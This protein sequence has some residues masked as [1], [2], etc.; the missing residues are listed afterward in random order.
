M[1]LGS[2]VST[3]DL[4]STVFDNPSHEIRTDSDGQAA[5]N[6]L[7]R[8]TGTITLPD[9]FA[10]RAWSIC[11]GL[12]RRPDCGDRRI[13]NAGNTSSTVADQKI[14]STSKY[15]SW[16]SW[17]VISK[18]GDYQAG[19]ASGAINSYVKCLQIGKRHRFKFRVHDVRVERKINN[20][21]PMFSVTVWGYKSGYLSGGR[22]QYCRYQASAGGGTGVINQQDVDKYFTPNATYPY[23]VINVE[24]L[25]TGGGEGYSGQ[26]YGSMSMAEMTVE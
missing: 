4:A 18:F 12:G 22:T 11:S 15:D 6:Y 23:L 2:E 21:E 3:K 17:S 1:S 25:S 10:N 20:T 7:R 14:T 24:A 16:P 13:E 9:S 19:T 26:V 5:Y 8:A